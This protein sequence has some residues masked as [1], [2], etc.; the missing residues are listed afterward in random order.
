MPGTI[1]RHFQCNL[2]LGKASPENLSVLLYFRCAGSR[3][4]DPVKFLCSAENKRVDLEN[5]RR[6]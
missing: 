1:T 5:F 4:I 3:T 2:N 6:N